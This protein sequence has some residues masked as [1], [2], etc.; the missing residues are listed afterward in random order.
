M[1][2]RVASSDQMTRLAELAK[3]KLGGVMANIFALHLKNDVISVEQADHEIADLT[4]LP[5][6]RTS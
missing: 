6:R 1:T 2:V 3:E 5:N 4:A